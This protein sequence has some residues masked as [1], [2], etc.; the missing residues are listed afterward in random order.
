[1]TFDLRVD[2]YPWYVELRSKE[3]ISRHEQL[4]WL[5][6]RYDEVRQVMADH[7]T[8]SSAIFE[9]FSSELGLNNQLSSMD[10]PRHTQLRS[11]AQHAFTPKAVAALEP[12]IREMASRLI[13]AALRKGSFDF[14]DDI[15]IPLPVN[16]IAEMLGISEVDRLKFKHW[17]D[18]IVAASLR[19]LHGNTD[20]LPEHVAAIREMKHYFREQIMERRK[21]PKE[22]L[23][24]R[25]AIAEID[26]QQ[27]SD[28]EAVE[29]CVLLMVAGNETTTHLLGNAVRTFL[30]FPDQWRL[31]CERKELIPQAI[32]EVLRFRSSVQMMNRVVRADTEFRGQSLKAGEFV[33]VILGSANRDESKFEQ[34]DRFDITRQ[35]TGQLAFGHGV[36]HCMGM[37][38]ARM[39]ARIVFEA[40][41]E[42]MPIFHITEGKTMEPLPTFVVHG[43]KKLP[44][45]AMQE[46]LKA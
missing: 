1:M 4:G 13:D 21:D 26:G 33:T 30:E 11:L 23:I 6:A 44:I 25:L 35:L 16:V 14:V 32:E 31:L 39:E 36:H 10:P 19:L 7:H 24:S 18:T 40:L 29:F 8:F 42:R 12:R 20:E 27:L 2:P 45:T 5:I 38:L 28:V 37:P 15:A 17:S 46:A 43:L 22:D 9:G 3:G 41:S 34:A